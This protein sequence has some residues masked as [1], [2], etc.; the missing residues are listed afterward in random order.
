MEIVLKAAALGITGSILAL[1]L[2]G[3]APEISL[4]LA[5]AAGLFILGLFLRFAGDILDVARSA[6]EIGGLSSAILSP[7]LKC[8]GIGI[9][10]HLAAQICRDA[11][12]GSLAAAM[13]LCGAFAAVY[14]SLPLIGSLISMIG[15]L[16]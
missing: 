16:A 3:R 11:G 5:M 6:A 9:V 15:E 12:Q 8:V 1:L 13:E 14:V 2:R 7:V 4:L 10:T